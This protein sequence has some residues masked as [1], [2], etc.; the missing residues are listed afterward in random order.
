LPS[1]KRTKR[2]GDV[3]FWPEAVIVGARAFQLSIAE[4]K[5]DPIADLPKPR[6]F[7]DLMAELDELEAD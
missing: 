7:N 2:N 6:T 3:L 1:S 5:R 4:P